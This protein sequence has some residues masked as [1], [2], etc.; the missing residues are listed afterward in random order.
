MVKFIYVHHFL[1]SVCFMHKQLMKLGLLVSMLGS[2]IRLK[3][4]GF[5]QFFLCSCTIHM[6]VMFQTVCEVVTDGWVTS[7]LWENLTYILQMFTFVIVGLTLTQASYVKT[8]TST[9]SGG[10]LVNM[11]LCV[12]VRLLS[13][14]RCKW[15]AYGLADVTATPSSLA[16]VKSRMVYLFGAGLPRL[17]WKKGR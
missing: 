7:G 16:P 2:V 13:A 12:H 10:N 17:S 9:S 6:Y 3:L 5:G 1:N 11:E 15:F 14:S 8:N 4:L